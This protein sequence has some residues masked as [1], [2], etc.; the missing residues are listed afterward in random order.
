MIQRTRED[1]RSGEVGAK[2]LGVYG[3]MWLLGVPGLIMLAL[4]AFGV[5]R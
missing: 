4:F 1:M 3:L 5:G 2:T